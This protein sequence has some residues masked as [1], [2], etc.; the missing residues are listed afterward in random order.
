MMERY[1][2]FLIIDVLDWILL[3]QMKIIDKLERKLEE[4][5]CENDLNNKR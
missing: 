2:K 3:L 1:S 4:K 5:R